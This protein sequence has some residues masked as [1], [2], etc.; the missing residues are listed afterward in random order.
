M[1]R[2][3]PAAAGRLG[4]RGRGRR[5]RSSHLIDV[6][7]RPDGRAAREVP[8]LRLRPAREPAERP[9]GVL[10]GARVAARVLAS[11][12]RRARSPTRSC[13][14]FRKLGSRSR[15][16]PRR[17]SPGSTSPPARS[18]RACRSRSGS[19]SPASA[20]TGC[21]SGSGSLCGDSEM[22]EGSMW[23]AFA[24]ASHESLDNLIAIIDVNRLG[25]RGETMLG[26]NTADLRRAGPRRSGGARS[27]STATTSPR[28]TPPSS[29][30]RPPTA[31]RSRSSPA[32]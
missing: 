32:P 8:P 4:P 26:W 15:A 9:S 31:S 5:L 2:A 30:P 3:G 25:Q 18:A 13:S 20:S 14:R 1:A 6:R 21:R 19:P 22:A 27:R 16:T 29:R 23:E 17:S 28:S 12:A 11:S 24:A 10:E 7:G